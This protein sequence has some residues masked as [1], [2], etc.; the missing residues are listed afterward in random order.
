MS[1][2]SPQSV[3]EIL[4]KLVDQ[5]VLQHIAELEQRVV[6]AEQIAAQVP[7]PVETLTDILREH[8]HSRA[9]LKAVQLQTVL[10]H[11]LKALQDI[12]KAPNPDSVNTVVGAL[13]LT[14]GAA[15]LNTTRSTN[16]EGKR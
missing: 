5:A 1:T 12:A 13:A 10:E 6:H 16:G 11:A 15:S 2:T 9:A 3:P 4:R 7:V 14:V 8:L